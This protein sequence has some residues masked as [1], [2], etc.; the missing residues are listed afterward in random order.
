VSADVVFGASLAA[1]GWIAALGLAAARDER[2]RERI[3]VPVEGSGRGP[4]SRA[5]R[6][7]AERVSRRGWLGRPGSYVGAVAGAAVAG[8]VV[9]A[10]LGGPV[11]ALA[12]VV[13]GPL[14]IEGWLSRRR[15]A[16]AVVT[17]Q[18]LREVVMALAAGVRA[19]R[20]V[21]GA[22][23][24]AA[25]DAAPPLS[26][27]L[28]R[29][30]QSLEVGETLDAALG[31]LAAR[32]DLPD[33]RLLVTALAIH[34]RTGGQLPVLLDEL[35]EVIG[36]RVEARREARALTAQGRASG[37]VL[38]ILPVAFVALLSGTGGDGLGA[39]Y[40][41]P[42]GAGLL[43]AGLTCEGLG[44]AWIRRVVRRVETER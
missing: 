33:A 8:L 1:S 38:A 17:E 37:V 41:T 21:R 34:R 4:R 7:L 12:G 16:A 35:A 3:G 28:E 15:S 26:L 20:S 9:G 31:R 30:L 6:W 40:R 32:L 42:L 5:V 27:E 44:F 43:A 2:L 14:A 19:G 39:F 29:A 10:R 11:G 23:E 36:Q 25:R 24:E 18:Q 13:G 22:L